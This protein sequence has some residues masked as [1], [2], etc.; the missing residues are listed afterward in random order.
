[1]AQPLFSYHSAKRV[2]DVAGAAL[3]CLALAPVL[4]A[5]AVLVWLDSGRPVLFRQTRTGRHGRPF[6]IIKFR[7]LRP[8][9]G[10][11]SDPSQ[12]ATRIGR[13]LRRWGLDELPQ[14][15]NIFRGDMS[16]VG[17]RPT[18]P[19]Q[20]AR[21][22]PFER[23]RLRVRPGLTGWAQI[24]GR[25]AI[26]WDERIA[27]DVWYAEHQSLWLDLRILLRTPFMLLSGRGSYGPDG[28]NSDYTPPSSPRAHHQMNTP[29]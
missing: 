10:L 6:Q 11:T 1:M 27:L 7:T 28:Q 4:I 26:P 5:I 2:A 24:H 8:G 17:P 16:L 3:L 25:N 23:Q 18:L 15:W 20:V 12:H 14:L 9:C 19:D 13:V 21:Y 22:G 29:S